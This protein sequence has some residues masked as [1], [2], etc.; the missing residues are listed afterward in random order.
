MSLVESVIADREV[1]RAAMVRNTG[2]EGT[3]DGRRVSP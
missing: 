3:G 2:E 1:A